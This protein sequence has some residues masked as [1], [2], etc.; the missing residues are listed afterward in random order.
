MTD[1]NWTWQDGD[2]IEIPTLN[3]VRVLAIGYDMFSLASQSEGGLVKGADW[4]K[5]A[6]KQ[7]GPSGRWIPHAVRRME[8]WWGH[9]FF[10]RISKS[11]AE[12][13]LLNAHGRIVFSTCREIAGS[14][15]PAGPEGFW[16]QAQAVGQVYKADADWL[17]QQIAKPAEE[18]ER[19]LMRDFL[20]AWDLV[21]LLLPRR[22]VAQSYGFAQKLPD[23]ARRVEKYS[24]TPDNAFIRLS[25]ALGVHIADRSRKRWTIAGRALRHPL[26]EIVKRWRWLLEMR[27]DLKR[28]ADELS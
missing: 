19:I 14:T 2:E 22:S 11:P 7:L 5:K 23:T 20:I 28:V 25:R 26:G 17:G 1:E 27:A 4:K 21:E 18:K 13:L 24:F 15:L 10:E 8:R 6:A 12:T 9:M 3:L 16:P